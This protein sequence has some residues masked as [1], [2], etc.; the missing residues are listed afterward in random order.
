VFAILI[1]YEYTISL[2]VL[3]QPT[4][5][6]PQRYVER[7]LPLHDELW[8]FRKTMAAQLGLSAY[9]SYILNIGDRALHK[10]FF[11]KK[12]ARLVNTEFYPGPYF[13]LCCR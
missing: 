10:I 5:C 13:V 12:T 2:S 6:P 3:V 9:L 7:S 8:A 4:A 1:F 11:S